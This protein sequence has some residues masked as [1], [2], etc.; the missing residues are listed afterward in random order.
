[1]LDEH[2]EKTSTVFL[3]KILS[4]PVLRWE[5]ECTRQVFTPSF[6]SFLKQWRVPM[7]AAVEF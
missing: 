3:G 2:R 6:V 7:T 4:I 1:M 5:Q